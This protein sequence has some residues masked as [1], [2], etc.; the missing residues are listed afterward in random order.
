MEY[1]FSRWND[2]FE[3]KH[4]GMPFVNDTLNAC[5]L[6]TSAKSRNDDDHV[7]S[8]LSLV[9]PNNKTIKYD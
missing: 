3:S 4:D 5:L 9:P 7:D 1:Y 8:D 2:T 6:H